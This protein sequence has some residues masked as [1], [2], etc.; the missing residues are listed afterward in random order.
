MNRLYFV[1]HAE[2]VANLTKEFSYRQ[3]DYSLTEKGVLQAQQTADYFQNITLDAVYASPLKR[4]VETAQ[5]IAAPHHLP[6]TIRENFREINCGRLEREPVSAK[7]WALYMD[8]TAD[9]LDGQPE[10]AF[11]DGENFP[12]LWARIRAG[13]AEMCAGRDH[14]NLV[15]VGHGG[16]FVATLNQFCPA[17]DINLLRGADA[18]NCSITEMLIEPHTLTGDLVRWND[19]THLH[20]DAAQIVRGWPQLDQ[21]PD[22]T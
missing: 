10:R 14:Q 5:F 11:P 16:W 1:R 20:G 6:V 13:F 8:I 3:V 9:W 4:A 17:A 21:L 12:A 7:N 18:V 2:N 15:L 22:V 19:H